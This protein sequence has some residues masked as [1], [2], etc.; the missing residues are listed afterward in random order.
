VWAAT[1]IRSRRMVAALASAN[2]REARLRRRQSRL[3]ATAA[4][5]SHAA[6]AVKTPDGR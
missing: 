4:I 2:G 3:C 1:A 6:F 5:D